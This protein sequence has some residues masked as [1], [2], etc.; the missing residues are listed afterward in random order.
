MSI[1]SKSLMNSSATD[2]DIRTV[3]S[4][5]E[6]ISALESQGPGHG[7]FRQGPRVSIS[8][9]LCGHSPWEGIQPGDCGDWD[10]GF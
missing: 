10:W 8:A 2:V 4:V 5:D 7:D 3:N 9:R 6:L 1:L